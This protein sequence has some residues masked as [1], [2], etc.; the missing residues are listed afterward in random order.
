M[1]GKQIWFALVVLALPLPRLSRAVV[2]L[3]HRQDT[4]IVLSSTTAYVYS[5][6]IVVILLKGTSTDGTQHNVFGLLC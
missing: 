4:L 3:I 1:H 5:V 6:V 2:Y